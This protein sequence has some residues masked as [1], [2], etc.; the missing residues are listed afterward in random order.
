MLISA[1]FLQALTTAADTVN[2]VAATTAATTPQ[3]TLSLFDLYLKGGVIMYPIT[4]L[5]L[6]SIYFFV[7]RYLT[8]SKA[9]K[10]DP[11]FIL[12]IKD[13]INSGNLK[14]AKSLCERTPTPYARIVE[15]GVTRIGN[16]LKNIEVGMEAVG[17][18]E[19]Y[20]LEK[21]LFVL[22]T[23]ASIAPMFGFL[24]TVFGMIKTF[25]NIA[26]SANIAIDVIAGGI[27]IKMVSSAAGLIVGLVSYVF[28]NY[29][30]A[31][32]DR[33][34]NQMEGV[35]FEFLEMLQEPAK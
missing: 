26:Q 12:Q 11:N 1:M 15:K 10:I 23:I 27:Y 18:L 2:R 7:E 8:I 20:K 32:I 29:L 6:I 4:L 28:Y 9:S 3:D 25:F 19:V 22:S 5:S 31:K 34:V 13:L 33:V 21:T 35:S 14:G 17:K 24:G 16:P 30:N